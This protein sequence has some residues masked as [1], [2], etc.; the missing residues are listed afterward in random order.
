MIGC[1]TCDNTSTCIECKH[2]ISP[3]RNSPTEG[4]TCP[5]GFYDNGLD[6]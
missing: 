2:S 4:C 1:L 5:E 3:S 6:D